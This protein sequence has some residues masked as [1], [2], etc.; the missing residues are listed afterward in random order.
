MSP[1]QKKLKKGNR[2][3]RDESQPNLKLD[4]QTDLV[5]ALLWV[6]IFSIHCYFGR[7][8]FNINYAQFD[9]KA[10]SKVFS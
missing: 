1:S 2:N 5:L 9:D 8:S 3:R 10:F 6:Q 7:G 4:F